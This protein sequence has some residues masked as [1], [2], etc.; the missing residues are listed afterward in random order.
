LSANENAAE[1]AEFVVE[2]ALTFLCYFTVFSEF[3]GKVRGGLF[4]FRS[5]A[6]ALGR[7]RIVVVLLGL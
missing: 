4:L 7:A 2:T 1:K 3:Q 5:A 6:L